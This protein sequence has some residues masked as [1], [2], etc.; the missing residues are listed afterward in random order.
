VSR[1]LVPEAER[2]RTRIPSHRCGNVWWGRV[3]RG[4]MTLMAW[5]AVMVQPVPCQRLL[6][7]CQ[8]LRRAGREPCPRR[9]TPCHAFAHGSSNSTCGT[10]APGHELPAQQL[11]GCVLLM[12]RRARHLLAT[13]PQ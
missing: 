9:Q 2:R 6:D 11:R 4:R 5:G 1:L 3:P 12:M 7:E 13:A 8:Q 10:R